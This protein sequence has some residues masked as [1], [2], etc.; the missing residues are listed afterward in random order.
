V[1]DIEGLLAALRC[2][3]VNIMNMAKWKKHHFGGALIIFI[4][5]VAASFYWGQASQAQASCIQ[6]YPIGSR[7]EAT[8][9]MPVYLTDRITKNGSVQCVQPAGSTGTVA[10]NPKTSQ[11]QTWLQVTWDSYCSGWSV[12]NAPLTV[13]E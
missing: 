3:N 8:T 4:G 2:Y 6:A 9:D 7:I 1:A 13:V 5:I 10:S 11:K 12:V